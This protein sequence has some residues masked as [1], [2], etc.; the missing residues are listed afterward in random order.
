MFENSGLFTLFYCIMSWLFVCATM[1]GTVQLGTVQKPFP[2][3]RVRR[4]HARLG[5]VATL[6][7]IGGLSE[8]PERC[9]RTGTRTHAL[10][11]QWVQ[12]AGPQ[13]TRPREQQAA[14]T[15]RMIRPVIYRIIVC[16]ALRCASLQFLSSIL[17]EKYH[18]RQ[19]PGFKALAPALRGDDSHEPEVP[20]EGRVI[21][22]PA[23]FDPATFCL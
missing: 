5:L 12:Q 3:L 2:E 10:L 18:S 20:P 23:G 11:R 21:Q 19:F 1:D 13:T 15:V 4:A 7:R 22:A 17:I 16:G 14:N 6:L 9:T 8:A